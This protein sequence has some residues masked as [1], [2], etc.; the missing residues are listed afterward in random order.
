M[1]RSGQYGYEHAQ[2][3]PRGK[4]KSKSCDPPPGHAEVSMAPCFGIRSDATIRDGHRASRAQILNV[5]ET[6][7]F[8]A[9]D[10]ECRDDTGDVL[11]LVFHL[12]DGPELRITARVRWCRKQPNENGPA[13]SSVEFVE[14]DKREQDALAAYS[15]VRQNADSR[16]LAGVANA[17]R[18]SAGPRL[19]QIELDGYLN[20]QESRT[21]ADDVRR[22]VESIVR[23]PV[24]AHID[25]RR[26][27]PCPE[28]S[29]PSL[30]EAFRSLGQD[31]SVLG[32]LLGPRSV[33]ML[34]LKR[35]AREAGIGDALAA[36][37]EEEEAFSF[38]LQIEQQM[39]GDARTAQA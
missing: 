27:A 31:G 29:L 10:G 34:Q 4:S 24:L 33:G 25:A 38:W 2:E 8:V 19:L 36:F 21:L 11:R 20:P 30:L 26:F 39:W 23:R 22:G 15:R 35:L 16:I 9:V 5:S 32:V 3:Q 7:A 12:P 17:F 1:N 28:S 14:L 37:E 6:G 18:V 13:G